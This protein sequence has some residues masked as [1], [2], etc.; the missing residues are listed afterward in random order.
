MP[1]ITEG[2]VD[3][4]HR[5]AKDLRRYKWCLLYTPEQ[6]DTNK[7]LKYTVENS[8]ALSYCSRKAD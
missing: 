8:A 5:D 1:F 2:F 6:K 3:E 7:A 4:P